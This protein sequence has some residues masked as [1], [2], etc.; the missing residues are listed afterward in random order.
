MAEK[1][2]AFLLSDPKNRKAPKGAERL[3]LIPISQMFIFFVHFQTFFVE[4]EKGLKSTK[5]LKTA[6][7]SS[8]TS[9]Q[10][11]QAH[12][13]WSKYITNKNVEN[14]KFCSFLNYFLSATFGTF[15]SE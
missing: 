4:P 12:E 7:K 1:N 10:V 13:S 5:R 3:Q 8:L 6:E 11:L 2:C 9:F 15:W 14:K